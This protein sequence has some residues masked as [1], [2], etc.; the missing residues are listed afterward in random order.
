MC[1][2]SPALLLNPG[3]PAVILLF[4]GAVLDLHCCVWT[5]SERRGRELRSSCDEWASRWVSSLVEV[6]GSAAPRQVE[7]SWTRDWSRA[8]CI[9]RWVPDHWATRAAPRTRFLLLHLGRHSCHPSHGLP[10][11]P[12]GPRTP[13][14]SG[15]Q[16]SCG[17]VSKRHRGGTLLWKGSPLSRRSHVGL[18]SRQLKGWTGVDLALP[19]LGTQQVSL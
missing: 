4:G 8:L 14:P 9:S 5:S 12:R 18:G 1:L 17:H 11:W 15:I 2:T 19:P 7:S 3:I 10:G 13:E 6:H 16:V